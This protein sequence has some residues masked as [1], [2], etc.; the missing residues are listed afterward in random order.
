MC[1]V[2]Y[3]KFLM[4]TFFLQR[5]LRL[6]NTVLRILCEETQN[7][8][9]LQF[10][11]MKKCTLNSFSRILTLTSCTINLFSINS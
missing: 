6:C 3:A 2:L 9:N 1:I 7:A 8:Y 4:C 11:I 5:S 10:C